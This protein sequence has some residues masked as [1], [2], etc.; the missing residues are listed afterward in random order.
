MIWATP[1]GEG[2][3]R[4]YE[5]ELTS[6]KPIRWSRE[7]IE[8]ARRF[9]RQ[10]WRNPDEHKR[11]REELEARLGEERERPRVRL[12]EVNPEGVTTPAASARWRD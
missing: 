10:Q 2:I 8:R 11:A 9:E 12:R 3:R 4:V 1:F 7:K 6:G 5:R